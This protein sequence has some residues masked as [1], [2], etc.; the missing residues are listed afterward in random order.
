M[1]ML[2]IL[3]GWM[4]PIR[5]GVAAADLATAGRFTTIVYG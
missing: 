1:P 4:L 2:G 3:N 5:F